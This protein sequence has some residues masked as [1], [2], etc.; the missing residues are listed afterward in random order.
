MKIRI[1][2][3]REEYQTLLSYP[4]DKR[5]IQVGEDWY[6][7]TELYPNML[8]AVPYMPINIIGFWNLFAGPGCY[9][10]M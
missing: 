5:I 2:I 1:Y 6:Q 3:N 8:K 4:C 10:I 7:V 9:V